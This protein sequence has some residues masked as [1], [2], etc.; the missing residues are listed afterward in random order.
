MIERVQLRD[1]SN[2]CAILSKHV[3]DNPY[4]YIDYMQFG[5]IGENINVY[6][7]KQIYDIVGIIYEYENSIQLLLLDD[8]YIEEVA[9]FL[10]LKKYKMISATQNIIKK[11]SFYM[12]QYLPSFGV[13]M[14]ASLYNS[15]IPHNVTYAE[16]KD[17]YKIASLI[18]S[19]D[20]IG[21][22]Y[23]IENLEKQLIYR[24]ENMH[25]RSAIIYHNDKIVSHAATY[26]EDETLAII[27]GVVTQNDYRRKGL[28][29]SVVASLQNLL[30]NEHKTVLLYC[31]SEPTINWYKKLNWKIIS[32]C[33]KLTPKH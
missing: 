19:D 31:Y 17:Y 30:I 23:S 15:I 18:C 10:C 4:L 9:T 33:G 26:A 1:N 21:S 20:G 5:Y 11:L 22:H 7:I 29:C 13:I 3:I 14:Q 8:K 6:L 32:N 2:I 27:G 12:N 16:K 24:M 25:C 28:G